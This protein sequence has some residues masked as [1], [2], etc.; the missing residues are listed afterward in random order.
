M[1]C[2]FVIV[3]INLNAVHTELFHLSGWFSLTSRLF[4]PDSK[5]TLRFIGDP[6]LKVTH[7]KIAWISPD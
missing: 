3:E 7:F 5:T 4:S 2:F 6:Q 1:E